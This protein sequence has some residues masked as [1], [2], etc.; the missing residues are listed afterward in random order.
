[1]NFKKLAVTGATAA[2][3]LSSAVPAFAT[4]WWSDDDLSLRIRNRAY[5]KND[6]DTTAN[7]GYNKIKAYDDVEGGRIRTGD[8]WASSAVLNDVNTN[9]VDLCGC[10]GDF[11]DATI[12]IKNGAKVKNYVDT[13]ANTGYNK[14]RS[15]DDDV[16]GGKINTGGAGAEGYVSNV[17]NTNVL[18]GSLE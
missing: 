17:V 18:G 9:I 2:L 14:I 13:T 1:M 11:D 7:T 10:L 15:Y 3:L 5:V 4:H 16:E 6:V 12:K 8:A